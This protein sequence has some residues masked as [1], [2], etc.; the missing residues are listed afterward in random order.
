[1]AR[2]LAILS[3][4]HFMTVAHSSPNYLM[5]A[6]WEPHARTWL[7]WPHAKADW[8]DKFDPIPWIFV[9]MVRGIAKSE[10]VGLLVKNAAAEKAAREHLT[11]VGVDLAQVSF[12]VTPTNR[13]WLRDCGPIFVRDQAGHLTALD[14]GFNGWA[15]YSNWQRDN[16]VPQA[17]AKLTQHS[18]IVPRHKGRR[19][20]LEGGGIEVDG[21]GTII[22]TEE[23][24]L[25]YTQQRN[26]G[27]TR[28]DYEQ[29][30]A[31][32]LGC[33]KTIWLGEGIVGDDTHGHV[34]DI[35][36]F[37]APARVVTVVESNKGDANYSRLKDNLAR[38]HRERDAKA[39][40]LEVIE[41]PMPEAVM[42]EGE[43]LPSSYANFLICNRTV[44]VPI[45]GDVNDRIALNVLAECFPDRAIYPI[46]ARDLVWGLGTIHCLTQQEPEEDPVAA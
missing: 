46:Y 10:A 24:L 37:V 4:E 14:W 12:H 17:I 40:A 33:T 20:V 29:I 21:E 22:V 38:L 42:C 23:W 1:M 39:R 35:T 16:G 19:V 6:E 18:R 9:E 8:P 34:D 5:P 45:F 13:G 27:F 11:R 32:Y 25:S 3:A 2:C 36:R 43:R 30:F 41:L 15:K 7:A 44:L 31:Q 28:H 26:P